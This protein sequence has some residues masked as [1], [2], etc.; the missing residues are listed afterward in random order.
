MRT[1]NKMRIRIG[2]RSRTC[3]RSRT[4]MPMR[5]WSGMRTMMWRLMMLVR[6]VRAGWPSFTHLLLTERGGRVRG[7]GSTTPFRIRQ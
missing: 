2:K 5:R 7:G 4:R 1:K 6:F 3:S